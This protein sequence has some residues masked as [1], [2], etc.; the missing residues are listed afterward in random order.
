MIALTKNFC[1]KYNLKPLKIRIEE[2]DWPTNIA[3]LVEEIGLEEKAQICS[4][5]FMVR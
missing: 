2:D 1:K 4:L 3:K 5:W